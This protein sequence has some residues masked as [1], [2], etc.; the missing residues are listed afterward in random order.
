MNETYKNYGLGWLRDLPDIRDY[1]P[2][3]EKIKPLLKKLNVLSPVANLPAKVD[4]RAW[5]APIEDQ[6][7]LGSCTANA[8]VGMIEFYE[9]KAYGVWLDASR[10]FLYKVT[11]NLSGWTGDTGAYLRTTMGAMTLFGVSPEKYWPYKIADFDVEP[12]AFL[13]AFAQSYQTI[14]YYRLDPAGTS[15]A[16]LLN[17]IKTNLAGNLP[18]MFGFTVYDSINQANGAGKGKIP[19]PS[20]KDKVVG[21]HAIVAV[22]YD[23]TLKIK[24]TNSGATTTGALLIRNSWGTSWGEEGYGWLPYEYVLKQVAVDWWALIKHEYIATKEFGL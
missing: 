6:G 2:E 4:L 10:L 9:K 7:Q 19:F 21:G 20:P 15:P 8:G 13:Y 14:N 17:Q 23:D 5:C 3:H 1:S 12:S 22:G 16:N 11:R 24:N 18:A